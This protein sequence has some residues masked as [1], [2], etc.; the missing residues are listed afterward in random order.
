M[1]YLS[2][3][4]LLL[5]LI[6]KSSNKLYLLLI[7]KLVMNLLHMKRNVKMLINFFHWKY[8]NAIPQ[9]HGL[10]QKTNAFKNKCELIAHTHS[11]V[12]I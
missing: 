6:I 2:K 4:C 12:Y 10:K 9:L 3:I 1:V 5:K 8:E 11:H 7:K